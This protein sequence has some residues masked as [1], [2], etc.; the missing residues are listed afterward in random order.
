MRV[1]RR[2]APVRWS[3]GY[4]R[5]EA[6][7]EAHP[8]IRH[9]L[10]FI[11]LGAI[12]ALSACGSHDRVTLTVAQV[13][14]VR[15][16][17]TLSE[18]S[19]RPGP[20]D[21][22][23]RLTPGA[24]ASTDGA[25]R[26]LI[27]LD[28]GER[29]LLDRNSR[30][31]VTSASTVDLEEGRAWVSASGYVDPL[32][33]DGATLRAGG[34]VLRLRGVR[35]SVERQGDGA[36][37]D[38]LGGE[39]AWQA[40]SR[41]GAVHAGEHADLRGGAANVTP[42]TLFDDWTGGLA[43]DL[44]TGVTVGAAMGLG[45]VAA[46]RPDEQGAP[47]WPLALQRVD[48]RVSIV[49]DL[50]VTELEETFFNPAGDTVEG[51]YTLTVPRG[52]VLQRFAVDRHGA[53]VD[54]F[55]REKTVAARDYQAQVYAG[56]THD[57][58]LLEWDAP[59]RYHARLYPITPGMTRK[60]L[61]TYTQWISPRADGG[62]SWRLPLAS[63]GTRVGELRVDVDV[64]RSGA[65]EVR[66]SEGARR[67]D[68]HV[69]FS[70]SDAIPSA[71]FVLDLRGA[72]PR[73]ASAVRVPP[74]GRSGPNEDRYG[75]VRV[76]VQAPAPEA[77][78]ARDEGVDLV[79]V[80]D[81]SAATDPV[82]LQLG[83]SFAEALARS[84]SE[85]DRILV[86]AGDVGT[87]AVGRPQPRLEPVTAAAR[88]SLL[89]A[90][91]RDRRGGATD[92][93]AMIEAAQ[94]ALDPMRNGA[95]VYIG[96]GNATVGEGD[97][98]ALRARLAR[99][100][101]HPRL[102]AV[103]VGEAPRLDLL[104][105]ITEPSGFAARVARRADVARTAL[106]LVEHA[107][108]PL[109]R[110]FRVDLGPNVERVYP[111]G[112][113]DVPAGEP[114]VIVGRYT[115]DPP[116]SVTVRASWNGR[117][118]V[119]TVP[120][121]TMVLSDH[122]DLRYRWASARLD[123]LLATGESRAVVVELGT[124][125]GLITPYTSL[126]VPSED[127]PLPPRNQRTSDA[128]DFS[129][130]DVIPLVGCREARE[131]APP[132]SVSATT[133]SAPS[134]NGAEESAA[135][136]T[137]TA[138]APRSAD[139]SERDSRREVAANARYG[140]R[141][142]GQP[143]DQTTVAVS[144]PQ[145][146]MV[147]IGAAGL[148]NGE[149]MPA[150]PP[151]VAVTEAPAA[152][153]PAMA[154]PSAAPSR[155]PA[156]RIA[157]RSARPADID[158][159][160]SAVGSRAHGSGASGG[161][162]ADA[163]HS[164]RGRASTGAN[165]TVEAT[166]QRAQNAGLLGAAQRNEVFA[167]LGGEDAQE[168]D[169]MQVDLDGDGSF[170]QRGA[171]SANRVAVQAA[172]RVL[173]RCSDAAAVTLAERV[174]LWRERLS[175]NGSPDGAA[176]VW[177]EA[178]RAC[179]LPAWPDR[180]ALL[181]LIVAE[182][183]DVNGQIALYQAFRHEPGARAWVRDVLLRTLART[184]EL[185]R[186]SSLGLARLDAETLTAALGHAT[187]PQERLN[188]LRL[189]A[190]RYPDDLELTLL[191]LDAAAAVRDE[192]EVRRTS[193]R[194]RED[195]RTDARVRTAV[196]EAL[197]AIGDEAEARRTFSEI[198]EFAPDDPWARRRLGDIG[199]AHGWAVEAYRQFQTLATA[200]NEAP[201]ILLRLAWAARAA[202]RFDEALRLAERVTTQTAPG[203]TGTVSEAAAAWIATELALAGTTT[204]VA[205]ETLA[206][207]RA[208]WRRSPAAR[209][210]GAVR[211]VLRWTHPDDEAELWVATSSEPSH[212]AD[213]VAAL[214]PLETSVWAEA[215]EALQVEVRRGGGGRPRGAAEVIVIWNEGTNRERVAH[216][217]VRFD[218]DH[219]RFAFDARDGALT[220]RATEVAPQAPAAH[221]GAR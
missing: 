192:A 99:M 17:V 204:G 125:F 185:A 158:D 166:R 43:D 87:R 58:A 90:L 153:E 115:R 56:S 68:T 191:L 114:L 154:A 107:S 157:R 155:E 84:L 119:R 182:V 124:R 70:Q 209:S 92:L 74:S 142:A 62:R 143:V 129:V 122:E 201:E 12:V 132:T 48:A 4:D 183:G 97:L 146:S 86:L 167:A 96:D 198:V 216:Q 23:L 83:Q 63:L 141:P 196:G 168:R 181:R 40:G 110:G 108:R 76:A 61:V 203:A 49:G 15:A 150:P 45:S 213:L 151:V 170:E 206:A 220:A 195:P 67:D 189:L 174:P 200:L 50:A 21:G 112:P 19:S 135:A 54:G 173:S 218:P 94:G 2:I 117:E 91:A 37:I 105:G 149:D 41:Q 20:V 14:R 46:R 57:P 131:A 118:T 217:T 69:T 1:A 123:H 116:G 121:S 52:A 7:S 16:G 73:D 9:T 221:G 5:L 36:S 127:E 64:S 29:V 47:R 34:A 179:E 81:H 66:A 80:V 159:L 89:D 176:R 98:P 133:Q 171:R 194:L 139:E 160:L 199:L 169:R 187:T 22:V 39:V 77:R 100:S 193:T 42:R 214:V 177:A 38:V 186:A 152:P 28:H 88:Q 3:R 161:G 13:E 147:P 71:D 175:T 44:P 145:P 60:V 6:G 137:P 82:S 165:A 163:W 113:V 212:R 164:D 134:V 65:N 144:P 188:V 128:R 31:R 101:P 102:Y 32:A 78:S 202:G 211:V 10:T 55:V 126:Y 51:I 30:L 219:M 26:A 11:G 190:R 72:P 93:G 207:L 205:P 162:G 103:A 215:P 148:R 184:G 172:A 18:A 109:V 25:G 178:K 130:F 27:T 8:M 136:T 104:A 33:G 35:A 210:S 106:D 95:I 59:G 111:N 140:G 24:V 85:R 120:L 75:F 180:V 79:V 197:L 208:R 53:M 156:L 138:Q